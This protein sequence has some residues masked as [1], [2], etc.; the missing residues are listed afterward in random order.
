MASASTNILLC[1][2]NSERLMCSIYT[3]IQE[4]NSSCSQGS[5]CFSFLKDQWVPC[6]LLSYVYKQFSYNFWSAL[7]LFMAGRWSIVIKP[8]VAR[9]TILLLSRR[10]QPN[11]IR[12]ILSADFGLYPLVHY[13][14]LQKKKKKQKNKKKLAGPVTCFICFKLS[15]TKMLNWQLR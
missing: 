11:S 15:V 1:L 8:R 10:G 12:E 2:L 13:L 14:C 3:I 4:L 5:S 7:Q 6:L 9:W